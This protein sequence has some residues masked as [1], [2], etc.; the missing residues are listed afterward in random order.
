MTIPPIRNYV[1]IVNK[2]LNSF[3]KEDEIHFAEEGVDE[4]CSKDTGEL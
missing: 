4:R 2:D 1:H 3:Y